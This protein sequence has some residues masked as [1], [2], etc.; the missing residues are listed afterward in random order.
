[1]DMQRKL[2]REI[3][4][5]LRPHAAELAQKRG[6][7]WEVAILVLHPA[8]DLAQRAARAA[9]WDGR[10]D[11]ALFWM[12]SDDRKRLAKNSDAVTAG[13]LLRDVRHPRI[14]VFAGRGT[15]LLNIKTDGYSFE[16]GSL[17]SDRI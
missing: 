12:P 8:D 9:G 2:K 16:R 14:F 1:M 5:A 7:A 13:W 10:T 4:E 11:P 17:D 15:F 6:A 3:A